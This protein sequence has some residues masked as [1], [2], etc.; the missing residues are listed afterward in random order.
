M[1]LA[2]SCGSAVGAFSFI[3]HF[4]SAEIGVP[5][6]AALLTILGY[7]V[8][9]TIV[10]FDRI[11]ENLL[12]S[13]TKS[14]FED[15]IS[16]SVRESL[17]RSLNSSLTTLF[18]LFAIFVFGGAT[19]QSFVLVLIIGIAIGTYSSIA[20][21]SPLLISWSRLHVRAARPRQGIARAPGK[22]DPGS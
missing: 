1:R 4:T 20:I 7:S 21:A 10:I 18:V 22:L 3:S 15:I 2:T 19:L 16:K 13:S 5:F 6:V 12:K 14:S 17:V 9:D 11:R 8:N